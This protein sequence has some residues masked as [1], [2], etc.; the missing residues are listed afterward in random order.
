MTFETDNTVTDICKIH[1]L[2]NERK[3]IQST[4]SK[5]RPQDHFFSP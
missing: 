3:M 4:Y 2:R 5:V 1:R